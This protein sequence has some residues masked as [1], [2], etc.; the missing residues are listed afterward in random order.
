MGCILDVPGI[1]PARMEDRT[2]TTISP[3]QNA[4]TRWHDGLVNLVPEITYSQSMRVL[5][6]YKKLKIAKANCNS[7]HVDIKHGA[8]MDADVIRR[9]IVLSAS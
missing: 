1:V 4:Q 5:A 8:F 2:M 6:Y 3:A 9:A 7:G